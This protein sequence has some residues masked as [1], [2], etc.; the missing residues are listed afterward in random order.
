[1]LDITKENM[2]QLLEEIKVEANTTDSGEPEDHPD[3]DGQNQML[4]HLIYTVKRIF[5]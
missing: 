1:M 4:D 2:L 3:L 5:L